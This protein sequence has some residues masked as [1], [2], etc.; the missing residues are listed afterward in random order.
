MT[1]PLGHSTSGSHQ[2]YKSTNRLK[3][4]KDFDCNVKFKQWIIENNLGTNEE[5]TEIEELC[6]NI[7]KDSRIEAWESY[8]K[9]IRDLNLELIGILNKIID[10]NN[11]DVN[12][13]IWV[14]R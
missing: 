4:E 6:K 13:K 2:R 8:Q 5:L 10:T 12:L 11:N 9:P 3:W 1:Q 7:V 14:D